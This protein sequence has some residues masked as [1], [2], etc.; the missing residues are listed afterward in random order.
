[1]TDACH[2]PARSIDLA[3][4]PRPRTK[5]MM[6]VGNPDQA[7]TLAFLPNDGVGLA[8]NEFIISSAIRVH[9]LALTRFDVPAQE[10]SERKIADLRRNYRTRPDYF[11]DRLA[12]GVGQIAAAFY[13]KDV[14][15]RAVRLQDQR[16]RRPARRR[17]ASSRRK[18]TR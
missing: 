3:Q 4:L 9:P 2:S 18:R 17:V 12:E 11:V 14:I 16:I 8:R 15:V 5:V 13:P 6:N 7:F 1:M 10:A